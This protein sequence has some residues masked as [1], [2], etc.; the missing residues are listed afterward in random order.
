MDPTGVGVGLGPGSNIL[1]EEAFDLFI[2]I[3]YR[4]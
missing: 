3:R 1:K 2:N 4:V